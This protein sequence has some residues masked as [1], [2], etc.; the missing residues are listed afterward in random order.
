MRHRSESASAAVAHGKWWPTW[1]WSGS[2]E[3][4]A[5]V[6]KVQEEVPVTPAPE[7]HVADTEKA[8]R[9]SDR[10]VST[11]GML[12]KEAPANEQKECHTVQE[13]RL[14]CA[15]FARNIQRFIMVA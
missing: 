7:P 1:L 6:A 2:S 10:F 8:V 14:W 15:M 12:C 5:P 9:A 13:E 4:A 3:Q 11:I